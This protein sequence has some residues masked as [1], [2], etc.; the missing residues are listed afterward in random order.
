[1]NQVSSHISALTVLINNKGTIHIIKAYIKKVPVFKDATSAEK[2][3]VA[4]NFGVKEMGSCQMISCRSLTKASYDITI[5][6]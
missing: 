5:Y 1:M 4:K 6:Q 3:L 2:K